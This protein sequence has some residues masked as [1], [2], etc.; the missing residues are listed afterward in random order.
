ME[1][2]HGKNC[3]TKNAVKKT[4]EWVGRRRGK[5]MRVYECPDCHYWHITKRDAP[6]EL[7]PEK[8]YD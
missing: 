2:C 3:Y 8:D 7:R 4:K 6:R 1:T 5:A